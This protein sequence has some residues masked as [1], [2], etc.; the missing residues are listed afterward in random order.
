MDERRPDTGYLEP[1]RDW[2][3]DLYFDEVIRPRWHRRVSEREAHALS[4]R[5]GADG[6]IG[7]SPA[8]RSETRQEVA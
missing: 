2:E 3:D 4:A 1:M 8:P 6:I 5:S 7:R